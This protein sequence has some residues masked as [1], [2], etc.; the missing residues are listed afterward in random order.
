MS[1]CLGVLSGLSLKVAL[2]DS[3]SI[4]RVA[5]MVS[6]LTVML[7]SLT[8]PSMKLWA[9]APRSGGSSTLVIFHLAWRSAL[10]SAAA[11]EAGRARAV[12]R[13]RAK[14]AGGGIGGLGGGGGVA[15][16]AARGGGGS[17][18]LLDVG[19]DHTA[20]VSLRAGWL[21][22]GRPWHVLADPDGDH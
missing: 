19:D 20:L 18:H 15:G 22:R 21:E 10:S 9:S 11:R 4:G 2:P 12:G 7:M 3:F 8:S 14:G 13:G 5:V 16:R 6:S 17:L 1:I